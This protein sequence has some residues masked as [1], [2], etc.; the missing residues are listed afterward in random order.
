M[1]YAFLLYEDETRWET[2][3]DAEREGLIGQHMAYAKALVE[4]GVMVA[5]EPLEPTH[6]A[7]RITAGT[8][9]DG[10]YA[11]TKEQLGGFYVV[12]VESEDAAFHW[13]RQ[14]PLMDGGSLEV[15]PIPNYG[16]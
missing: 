4:A 5:G 7:K 16:G 2:M 9:H 15:R 10:P 3:P 11:D 6:S 13:A 12:D 1:K 8:V 14:C